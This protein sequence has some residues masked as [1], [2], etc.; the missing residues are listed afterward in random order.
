[1]SDISPVP[2]HNIGNLLKSEKT[3]PQGQGDP[4]HGKTAMKKEIAIIDK[5]IKVF[6]IKQHSQIPGKP[7][8]QEQTSA[9]LLTHS[10]KEGADPVIEGHACQQNPEIH[11]IIITVKPERHSH[12]KRFRAGTPVKPV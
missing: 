8:P 5:E 10:L 7:C 9:R 11:R 12:Q 3:D 2:F 6:K 1:M 4:F